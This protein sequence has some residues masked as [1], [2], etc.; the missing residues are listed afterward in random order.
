MPNMRVAFD[1]LSKGNVGRL[2]MAA[3]DRLNRPGI[4]LRTIGVRLVISIRRNI[5]ESR[6]PGGVNYDDLKSPRSASH[7]N[8]R[9]PTFPLYDTGEMYDSITYSPDDPTDDVHVG[10]PVFYSR[11]QNLGTATIP[12]RQFVGIREDD[13]PEAML[14]RFVFTAFAGDEFLYEGA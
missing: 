12:S 9:G 11:F 1:I 10:T 2:L 13:I 7:A 8:K 4:L 3:A 6:T 5:D 14:E